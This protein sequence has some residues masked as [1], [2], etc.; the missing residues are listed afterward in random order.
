VTKFV[1]K[2]MLGILVATRDLGHGA[3]ETTELRLAT[4]TQLC[5]GVEKDAVS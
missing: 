1:V 4:G 2:K 5:G 3:G